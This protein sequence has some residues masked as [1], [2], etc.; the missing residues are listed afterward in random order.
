MHTFSANDS[1]I[2]TN[3]RKSL[4]I[5]VTNCE[6]IT[7]NSMGN[8]TKYILNSQNV[9]KHSSKKYQEV[10]TKMLLFLFGAVQSRVNFVELE[11]C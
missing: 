9:A 7:S 4:K 3:L 5:I 6:E 1:G 11:K 8:L 2:F 10:L